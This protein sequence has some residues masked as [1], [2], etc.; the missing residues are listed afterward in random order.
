M[1]TKGSKIKL[2]NAMG[3]F[4][5]IGEVC[6]VIKVTEDGVISFKFGNGMHL[7]CMSF[8]EYGRYFVDYVEPQKVSREWSGWDYDY[9]NY[10]EYSGEFMN[11]DTKSRHNGKKVQIVCTEGIHDGLKAEA[12]C[13]KSDDFDYDKG[14]TLAYARLLAKMVKR[15]SELLAKDM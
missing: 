6:D 4:N 8:D 13:C 1:I 12:T 7:G 11:Y 10:T 3:E 9:V 5:N 2:V 14:Y 15:D